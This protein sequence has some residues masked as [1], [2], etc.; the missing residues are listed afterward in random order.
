MSGGEAAVFGNDVER[1]RKVDD[2]VFDLREQESYIRHLQEC[3]RSAE[4]EI[5]DIR[6]KLRE[7]ILTK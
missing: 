3:I 1:Q 6:W 5:A 4:M 7:L 2:L